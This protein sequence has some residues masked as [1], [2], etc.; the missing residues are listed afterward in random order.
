MGSTKY[1]D[2]T[3]SKLRAQRKHAKRRA[4]ERYGLGLGRSDIAEV[5]KKIQ[6][7]EAV[8]V[9]KQSGR[10]SV[11]DVEVGGK[12]ARV[13]YDKLRKNIATFLPSAGEPPRVDLAEVSVGDKEEIVKQIQA[14]TSAKFVKH[15]TVSRSIWDVY[16]GGR[17]VRVLYNKT[18]KTVDTAPK[19]E[20]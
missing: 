12:T 7:G 2:T 8:F 20:T 19:E 11:W 18:K 3:R 16:Y 9:E 14:A 15:L 13:V 5:V 4:L 1:R 10:V 6:A 17:L